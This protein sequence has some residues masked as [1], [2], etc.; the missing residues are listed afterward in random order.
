MQI[1]DQPVFNE[2]AYSYPFWIEKGIRLNIYR[3]NDDQI[4]RVRIYTLPLVSKVSNLPGY[5]DDFYQLVK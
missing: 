2:T 1:Y 4:K 5:S 3:D